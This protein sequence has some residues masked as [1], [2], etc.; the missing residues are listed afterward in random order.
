MN[1]NSFLEPTEKICIFSVILA[2]A[3]KTYKCYDE[4]KCL[5][6]MI[7]EDT[8]TGVVSPHNP[9]GKVFTKDTLETIAGACCSHDCL[10]IT[11]EVSY[12]FS[13]Y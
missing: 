9:T 6:E 8:N 3:L 10:A 4:F 1:Y 2:E 7:Y 11:D 12:S 13:L 5:K